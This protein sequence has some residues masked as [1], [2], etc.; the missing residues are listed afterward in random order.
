MCKKHT[1]YKHHYLYCS[2]KTFLELK[3]T[4]THLGVECKKILK[5]GFGGGGGNVVMVTG[6]KNE[7]KTLPILKLYTRVLPTLKNY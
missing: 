1:G 3:L 2:N 4:W 5:V 7:K 6:A